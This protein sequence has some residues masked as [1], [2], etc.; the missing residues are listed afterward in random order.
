MRAP[1]PRHRYTL[2]H[3]DHETHQ[4]C[5]A[6]EVQAGLSGRPKTIPCRFLYDEAG[7]QLFEEIC[8]VP[9]Y[10]VT[11]IERE[12][13]R[14]RAGEIARC[15][16][17]PITLAELGSGS[18][19]KTRLLIEALLRAHGRLRY[20][21]VDISRSMLEESSA[22][23]LERYDG[24]E[25]MAI[26]SEYQEGLRHVRAHTE[27]PKL[28]AWLGSSIGNLDRDA[29]ASFLAGVRSLLRPVDRML[30]GIDLRKDAR[31]LEAAYDDPAGVTAR[32]SLNLLQRMNRELGAAF[33]LEGFRHVARYLEDEGRIEIQLQSLRRQ[34]VAFDALGLQVS[35]EAGEGIYTEN[36]FKYSTEE[37][38]TLARHA[39]MSVE[40]RW[41]DAQDHFSVNLLAPAA[42]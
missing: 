29:A 6:D 26:A 19:T 31:I 22:D 35:F 28:V 7:S 38:D 42:G 2:I 14:D 20:V 17:D 36:A 30:V 12:I 16:S 39:G 9:E 15:F 3:S 27:R 33:D 1:S 32:F 18:S 11:R 10:Y 25:V 34:Q 24:L 40:R 13:L 21:P 23:L 8:E 4:A 41:T 5:F 37:I